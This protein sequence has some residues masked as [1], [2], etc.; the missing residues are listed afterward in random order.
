MSWYSSDD[1]SCLP[2]FIRGS[3]NDEVVDKFYTRYRALCDVDISDDELD[4]YF[5]D[6][7][8]FFGQHILIDYRTITVNSGPHPTSC[9]GPWEDCYYE[10][11]EF[12]IDGSDFEKIESLITEYLNLS[13]EDFIDEFGN[14]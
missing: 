5:F 13:D 9:Y 2:S 6:E 10:S 4:E 1:Y 12:S 11:E 3:L 7:G 8:G 14:I